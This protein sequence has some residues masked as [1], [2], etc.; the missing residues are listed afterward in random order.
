MTKL[1]TRSNRRGFT[2]IELLVVIAII[3]ILIGLLL[4]AVQKVREAAARSDSMNNL[5]QIG[6]ASHM[7]N[8]TVGFLPYNG[9][10]GVGSA[11]TMNYQNDTATGSWAFQILP[12]IE[13]SNYYN[14]TTGFPSVS[15]KTFACKGRGRPTTQTFLDYAWNCYLNSSGTGSGTAPALNGNNAFR[16]IQGLSNLDGS[17]TTIM[18][19]HKYLSTTSWATVTTNDITTGGSSNAGRANAMY[20]RDSTNTTGNGVGW[21]GPFPAGGCF[22]MG[23]ASARLI[24]YSAGST[25]S[26][27]GFTASSGTKPFTLSLSPD[28]GQVVNLPN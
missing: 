3:A 11:T 14:T 5:K 1:V 4:P 10:S 24:P 18:A 28:D 8:D 19:G 23:D 13:Q 20:M 7:H 2:L 9:K 25:G 27:T 17:S 26:V 16:T 21:G 15:I 22:V 6:T 12:Y